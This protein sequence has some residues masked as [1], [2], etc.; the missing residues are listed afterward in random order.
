MNRAL[1]VSAIL[2]GL[3]VIVADGPAPAQV[4]P[5]VALTDKAP[6]SWSLAPAKVDTKIMTDRD[7][8][9]STVAKDLN[10]GTL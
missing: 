8:K 5:Y 3:L 2:A 7:Y 9:F 6:S 10:G 1:P 4:S